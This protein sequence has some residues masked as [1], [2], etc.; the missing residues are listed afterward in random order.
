MDGN[1]ARKEGNSAPDFHLH[2]RLEI[3]DKGA[4]AEAEAFG[5]DSD[6][7]G[8]AGEFGGCLDSISVRACEDQNMVFG[9]EGRDERRVSCEMRVAANGVGQL[10]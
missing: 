8:V 6:L 9:L 7:I 3:G 10:C 4:V 2:Q 5:Q 1:E